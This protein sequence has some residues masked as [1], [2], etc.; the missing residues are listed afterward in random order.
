MLFSGILNFIGSYENP[1]RCGWK[2][3][4]DGFPYL[5]A[6]IMLESIC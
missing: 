3:Q 5:G 6:P 2:V 1:L 4:F